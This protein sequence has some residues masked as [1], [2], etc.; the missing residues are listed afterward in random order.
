MWHVKVEAWGLDQA[1]IEQPADDAELGK[2][3]AV[4]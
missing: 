2:L 4:K 3:Q 1:G